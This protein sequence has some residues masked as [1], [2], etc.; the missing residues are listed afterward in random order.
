ML[1]SLSNEDLLWTFCST[2][3]GNYTPNSQYEAILKHVLG[4]LSS[5]IT[6][7]ISLPGFYNS[8]EIFETKFTEK[9]F[10]EEILT[11]PSVKNVSRMQVR[12]SLETARVRMQ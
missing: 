7:N 8:L 5:N 12:I 3:R 11:L 1:S 6:V 10:V 9:P 4:E 2:D